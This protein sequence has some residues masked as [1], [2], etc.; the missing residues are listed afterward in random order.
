MQRQPFSGASPQ[1]MRGTLALAKSALFILVL[2]LAGFPSSAMADAV[3]V[4]KNAAATSF[5]TCA[6][7]SEWSIKNP[8]AVTTTDK[9]VTCRSATPGMKDI[10]LCE[11]ARW[12]TKSWIGNSGLVGICFGATGGGNVEACNISNGGKE[13][14]QIK[15]IV[16]GT[17][18]PAPT[19]TL[20]ATPN[21]VASGAAAT[22]N[23]SSTNATGC[24]ASGG[25]SGARST[26]GSSSTGAL[27]ATTTYVLSCSGTGG[28]ASASATVTVTPPTPAPTV[29]LTATP[30][31]LASGAAATLNWSSTNATGCT[32]SGG[33]SGARSTSGSSSTGALSATITYALSCSG[34]GGSASAS[35]TV[36]VTSTPPRPTVTLTATPTS[37]ASG[38]A[39]TL[40]WSSTNATGCT[41]SGG[42]SGA[43]STSGSSSTGALSATITYALSCS[44]AGGSASASATV[45]VTAPPGTLYGLEWPGNGAVRRMLYWHNPFPI[46][47][48]TYVFRVYPRK[49]TV[50]PNPNAYFTTFFWGNDGTF[51]WDSG[52]SANTYYGAHPYPIP[53]TERPRTV[54]DLRQQQRL[55]HRQ[56]SGWNRWYTQAFRAW[57]ESPSI[58]H[59]EFY[60]DL[61][62]TSKVIRQDH[63]PIR[64]GP[65]AIRLGRRSCSGRR[66]T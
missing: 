58:T 40:S 54:G 35:A 18:F 37:V 29:T 49:K 36:T 53:G 59:H 38:G 7:P 57:R 17:G 23:W 4:C 62:D 32:A 19:V 61:P 42:W 63:L 20:T 41:A 28:S 26:S 24:T 39:A 9:V 22:L 45:M 31:S 2:F 5:F 14:W 46:Y 60:W 11:G 6:W 64:P 51:T 15:S 55:R 30:T 65:P 27:S 48:A 16:F 8:S 21:S 43:R 52:G 34:A 47:D 66:R 56:R 12:T 1:V 10:S 50:P 3:F 44:G 13:G 25:W 33:W